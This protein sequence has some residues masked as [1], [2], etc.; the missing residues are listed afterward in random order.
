M[1]VSLSPAP[2]NMW[3]SHRA[4]HE[5]TLVVQTSTLTFAVVHSSYESKTLQVYIIVTEY[6]AVGKYNSF[7]A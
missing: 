4:R 3:Y 2:S 1:V 6:Q 5:V 7:P